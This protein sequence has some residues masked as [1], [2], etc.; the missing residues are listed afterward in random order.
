MKVV[1]KTMKT[2]VAF[3]GTE[4]DTQSDCLDYEK[5]KPTSLVT[6][7][8]NIG[9]MRQFLKNDFRTVE[10]GI[11]YHRKRAMTLLR[12]KRATRSWKNC[13]DIAKEFKA[14]S[15]DLKRREDMRREK[16]EL[17]KEEGRLR[18]TLDSAKKRKVGK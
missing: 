4:F 13:D 18:A 2:Y 6:R 16:S 5:S 12:V 7:L 11:V 9:A 1:E 8:N 15:C 3:D 17:Y 14:L 10:N